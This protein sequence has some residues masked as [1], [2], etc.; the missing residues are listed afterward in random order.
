MTPKPISVFLTDDH[1]LV[2]SGLKDALKSFDEIEVTGTFSSGVDL[3]NEIKV[4]QPDI[5]ILDLQMPY[6]NG[7]QVAKELRS[8]YPEVKIIILSAQEEPYF[9]EE[10]L[11]LGCKG[12]LLK[13]KTDASLLSTAIQTVYS[14][15]TFIEPS[16]RIQL[17]GKIS[18]TKTKATQ[19][20]SILTKKEK[21]ILQY[22]I[23]GLSSKQI[24]EELGISSRTVETH[25][26][27]LLQKLDVKNTANLVKK[28]LEWHLLQ[29]NQ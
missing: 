17:M 16:M 9:I 24:A 10:M 15:E 18:R 28:A 7:L 23:N 29:Q 22:L 19:A 1:P 26:F 25:R 14:G 2:L 6:M 8:H 13:S 20:A 11:T 5:L 4:H 3:L 27:N 21:E 12:Y